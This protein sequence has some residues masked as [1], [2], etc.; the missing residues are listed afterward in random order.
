M[1][2]F[3][4]WFIICEFF[5][6]IRFLQDS[7]RLQKYT[8]CQIVDAFR[9]KN[10]DSWCFFERINLNMQ[11]CK[12][13]NTRP[14]SHKFWTFLCWDFVCWRYVN[15]YSLIANMYYCYVGDA[16]YYQF[17]FLIPFLNTPFIYFYFVMIA[18]LTQQYW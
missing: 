11:F 8:V 10:P 14:T 4:G 7:P 15:C 12:K 6:S 17:P 5:L 3:L 13:K 1:V 18:A 16:F 2:F 9:L